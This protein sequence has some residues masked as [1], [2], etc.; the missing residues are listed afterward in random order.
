MAKSYHYTST[1]TEAN[2]YVYDDVLKTTSKLHTTDGKHKRLMVE[3]V[4]GGADDVTEV[5]YEAA[6]A[7]YV[8]TA[9]LGDHPHGIYR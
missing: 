5:E 6:L 1:E 4:P 8:G 2:W 9:R 7:T 3:E